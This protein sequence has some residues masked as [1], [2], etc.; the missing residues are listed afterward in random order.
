MNKSKTQGTRRFHNGHRG[1]LVFLLA[2]ASSWTAFAAACP[3]T[4]PKIPQ[5]LIDLEHNWAKAL[6]NKDAGAVACILAPEFVDTAPDG[7]VRNREQTLAA[8]AQRK[9]STNELRDLSVT[10]LDN[11]AV[12]H[13]ANHVLDASGREIAVVRFTD[14]FAYRNGVWKAVSG[15]ESVVTQKP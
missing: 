15:H 12:V 8:I 11:A 14:V 7:E 9:N 5:A 1:M 4:Q 6:E 13:G 10:M 2:V 3:K